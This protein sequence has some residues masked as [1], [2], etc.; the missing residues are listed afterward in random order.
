MDQMEKKAF[1]LSRDVEISTFAKEEVLLR[2]TIS[3]WLQALN[4]LP[5]KIGESHATTRKVLN[6]SLVYPYQ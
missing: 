4:K 5:E 3:Q 1:Y 2:L 6:R